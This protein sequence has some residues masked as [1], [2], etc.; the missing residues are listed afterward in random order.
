MIYYF[1]PLV[2]III[3]FLIIFFIIIKKLP[4]LA[5]INIESIAQEKE[6]KVRNRLITERLARKFFSLKKILTEIFTPLL[7]N[8]IELG[9]KFY[10][11]INELERENLKKIQPLKTIDLNQEIKEKLA[12]AEKFFTDQDLTQAEDTCISVVGLDAKNLEV[13]QILVNIYLAKKEYK[14]ARETC[15]YLIK[16]LIKSGAEEETSDKKHQLANGY[17]DLGW[18]YQMERKNNYALSNFSKAV[19]LEPVNPRFLD[20]LLK[21]SIIL[22]NKKLARQAFS[23]LKKA[24]PENQKLEE[25]KAEIENLPDSPPKEG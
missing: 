12:M 24:D 10:Q 8:I 4:S 7:E 14:K 5:V 11:I 6:S 20:L 22:K 25:L 18:I 1:I 2:V 21:I 19:G 13:Y 16:L 15:R 9:H 3:S 17:A 23:D